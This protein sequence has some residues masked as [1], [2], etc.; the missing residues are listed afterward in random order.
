[1]KLLFATPFLAGFSGLQNPAP[2]T[3]EQLAEGVHRI[4][5]DGGFFANVTVVV[6][7]DGVL[8]V[9]TGFKD[10]RDALASTLQRM[11]ANPVH[12]IIHTHP[13]GDHVGADSLLMP[14][15]VVFGHGGAGDFLNAYRNGVPVD[16]PTTIELGDETIHL[17]PFAGGHSGADLVVHFEK[18]KV[19]CLGDMY[20]SE[21]FPC[22]DLT[23]GGVDSLMENL[24]RVL[25]LFPQDVQVVP[26]H[27]RVTTMA[28][29]RR[30]VD[31]MNDTI[32]IVRRE[33]AAGKGQEQIQHERPL[34]DYVVW[35]KFFP[36]IHE[37]GWIHDIYLSY[38]DLPPFEESAVAKEPQA[39]AL[40]EPRLSVL[41][42]HEAVSDRF[43]TAWGFSCLIEGYADP[44]LFDTGLDGPKL[45]ANMEELKIDPTTIEHVVL[46]HVHGDHTRGFPALAELQPALTV[47][48]LASFP[49]A[50]NDSLGEA[51][52]CASCVTTPR[53]ILPGLHTTGDLGG[54]LPEQ[55]IFL[56]T[57]EGLVIV[58]GCAHPGICQIVRRAKQ[59]LHRP[60]HL[61][62][63]G[64]H[65]VQHS[66]EAIAEII[67]ELRDVGVRR[68]APTHCTGDRAVELFR[69]AWGEDFVQVLCGSVL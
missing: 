37:E 8:L 7:D 54:E 4:V 25:E 13:H 10:T 24:E 28:G 49:S 69:E 42:N 41:F 17:V 19:L 48:P 66:D 39:K 22:V 31:R 5:V 57:P 3:V 32:A 62:M 43:E 67:A 1:M 27:G 6:G 44:V 40:P 68:V 55:A 2:P 60:I 33:M 53:E 64:F 47:Y 52:A 50:L 21:S 65:L 23:E 58:T 9:D 46:S 15:G 34:R 38:V 63:G 45:L 20:L 18:A 29:L 59:V 35:G 14:D 12:T 30:Y 36:F 11:G 56:E 61:V 26:G 51:C 16:E